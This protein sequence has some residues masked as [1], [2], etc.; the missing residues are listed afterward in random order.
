MKIT[1]TSM[2]SGLTRTMEIQVSQE[3]LDAWEGGVLIQNAMPHLTDSEREF[4]LSGITDD[5]WDSLYTEEEYD[6]D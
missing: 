4:I 1:R 6:N 2:I 5:E 3:Q